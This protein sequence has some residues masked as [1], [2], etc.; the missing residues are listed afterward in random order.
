EVLEQLT[1]LGISGND[2]E[3]LVI[4]HA[5]FDHICG[6]P[7]LRQAFPKLKVLASSVAAQ[8]LAKPKV[9]QGFFDEDLALA[10]NLGRTAANLTPPLCID[11]D[12][13]ISDGE[14][15]DL[16]QG[17]VL[18]FNLL[19]GHSPCSMAV[20][21]PA[22]RMVFPSDSS[23]YPISE[24]DLFPM[25]FYNY[26]EYISSLEKLLKLDLAALAGPH[27]LVLA[28]KNRIT[29]YLQRSL[30]TT[31]SLHAEILTAYQAGQSP[32]EISSALYQRFYR[33]GIAN[34]SPGNIRTCTDLLVR[35]SLEA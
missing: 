26:K 3:Y 16:G 8:V 24:D 18:Q 20:Y 35:R 33:G 29:A 27:E 25:Y 11:V 21:L 5:H 10:A 19:P 1:E 22:D 15:L 2:L 6:I 32:E 34:Y 14:E 28:D 30:E 9:V 17:V 13:E 7:V 4:T 31:R 23:G 12:K